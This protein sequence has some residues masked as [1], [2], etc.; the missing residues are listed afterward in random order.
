MRILHDLR[1][2]KH[3][4]FTE[5]C[6]E[7]GSHIGSWPVAERYGESIIHDLNNGTEAWTDWNLVLDQTGGPNHVGNLCSAP[8][9]A[10][11]ENDRIIYN[12]SYYY[13]AQF[14][15][16]IR[17]GARRILCA[18][19]DDRVECTAFQNSGGEVVVVLMNRTDADRQV[20]IG[21]NG[22]TQIV[23]SKAYSLATCIWRV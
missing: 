8:I 23:T 12:P 7:G 1:P 22:E 4:I 9:L 19:T 18:A 13:L 21:M 6:Q 10:D 17:P 20:Q 15:R 16:Y 2:D 14:A 5:G 11:V 3:L